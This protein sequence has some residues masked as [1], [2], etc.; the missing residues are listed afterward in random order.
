MY[1]HPL[2]V[3]HSSIGSKAFSLFMRA[4]GSFNFPND[5]V[6]IMCF[7]MMLLRRCSSIGGRNIDPGSDAAKENPTLIPCY[8]FVKQARKRFPWAIHK[9]HLLFSQA[10]SQQHQKT[11]TS[12]HCL[13][14]RVR[15]A[16]REFS[17]HYQTPTPMWHLPHQSRDLLSSLLLAPF[18]SSDNFTVSIYS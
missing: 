7:F 2:E 17:D 14:K 8:N 1:S 4:R 10:S 12:L 13:G 5:A 15:S 9:S 18:C 6:M 16:N 3:V 11:I